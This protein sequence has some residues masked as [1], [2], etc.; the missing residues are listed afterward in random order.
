[1][2]P[3]ILALTALS[4]LMRNPALGGGG[5]RTEDNVRLIAHLVQ[6]I[7]GGQKTAKA[8]KEFADRIAAMAASGQNPT[9]RDFAEFTGRLTAAMTVVAEAKAKVESRKKATPPPTE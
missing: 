2:D 5:T 3:I 9:E 4:T 7:Q 6:L 1:M 8:L